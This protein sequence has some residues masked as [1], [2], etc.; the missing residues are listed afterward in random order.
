MTNELWGTIDSR[1]NKDSPFLYSALR[2]SGDHAA[3]YPTDTGVKAAGEWTDRS[4]L[5]SAN[6]KSG[7]ALLP[8]HNISSWHRDNF[9]FTFTA[10]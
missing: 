9:V 8:L 6:V 10:G 1:Q 2:G 7:G 4:S 5:S 3:S